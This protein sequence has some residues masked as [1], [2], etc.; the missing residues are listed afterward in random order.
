MPSNG[1]KNKNKKNIKNCATNADMSRR[2]VQRV[3]IQD[4]KIICH[5]KDKRMKELNEG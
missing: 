5:K 1:N 4:Y 2:L 3:E